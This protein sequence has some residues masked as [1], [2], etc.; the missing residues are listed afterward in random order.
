MGEAKN[1]YRMLMENLLEDHEGYWRCME[2]TQYHVH[3]QAFVL[4][5]LNLQILLP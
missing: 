3:W 4:A 1:A 5:V 2:L